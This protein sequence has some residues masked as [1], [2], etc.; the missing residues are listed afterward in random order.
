M[1][2]SSGRRRHRPAKYES[3]VRSPRKGRPESTRVRE[4]KRKKG[5]GGV[6]RGKDRRGEVKEGRGQERKDREKE[7]GYFEYTCI[8]HDIKSSFKDAWQQK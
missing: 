6:R 2:R 7:E 1:G 4:Q 8:P 3:S 5:R